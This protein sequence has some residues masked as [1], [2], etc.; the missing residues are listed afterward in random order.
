M[1]RSPTE[2][3]PKWLCSSVLLTHT[4][5]K[6]SHRPWKC[7]SRAHLGVTR[8]QGYQG[9]VHGNWSWWPRLMKLTW[10][11]ISAA[12]VI[13]YLLNTNIVIFGKFLIYF[14]PLASRFRWMSSHHKHSG[15]Y[16]WRPRLLFRTQPARGNSTE[17]TLW[18][19]RSINLEICWNVWLVQ[20]VRYIG[21]SWTEFL[22]ACQEGEV[23]L[24]QSRRWPGQA[25]ARALQ[26]PSQRS[27]HGTGQ[28]LSHAERTLRSAREW[29]APVVFKSSEKY[30]CLSGKELFIRIP[31]CLPTL[32]YLSW[33]LFVY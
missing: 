6:Y 23:P 14:I 21:A 30:P 19:A 32:T 26:V 3:P 25:G 12:A 16:R 8:T 18:S 1:I 29:Q 27:A 5:L 28:R 22:A 10:V 17:Q 13:N 24:L 2:V 7:R 9:V 31:A 4:K 11:L 20:V 15:N 33:V